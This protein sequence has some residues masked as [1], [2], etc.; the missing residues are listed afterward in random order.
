[1]FQGKLELPAGKNAIRVPVSFTYSNR[2]ELIKESE[3]R[4]QIGL[5]FNLDQLFDFK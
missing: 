5:S 4:G 3:V 1:V 2:T